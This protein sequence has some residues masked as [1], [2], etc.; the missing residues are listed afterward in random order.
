MA[1]TDDIQG[2]NTQLY[3]VVV[4]DG[5]YYSTN[6]V[7]IDGNY[8]KPILMN[9]PSIKESIDIESRKFKISN[10]SLDFNNFPF[11]GERFSDQL[12]ETSLINKEAIIYFKSSSE[13]KELFRATV[14]RISHDDEKVRV[15]LEDLTEK[16]AHKDLPNPDF[17]LL[18]N[19]NIPKKYHNKYTPLVY[20]NVD[21]CP[22]VFESYNPISG[23][24]LLVSDYKSINGISNTNS[25]YNET[26][27]LLIYSNEQYLHV[28]KDAFS[29]EI[30]DYGFKSTSQY[31]QST[32]K[33]IVNQRI[34]QAEGDNILDTQALDRSPLSENMCQVVFYQQP[35]SY[36]LYNPLDNNYSPPTIAQAA[37]VDLLFEAE[38]ISDIVKIGQEFIHSDSNP[39]N[40]FNH[41]DISLYKLQYSFD[42]S[43]NFVE[44]PNTEQSFRKTFFY[45]I[46]SIYNNFQLLDELSDLGIFLSK[47]ASNQDFELLYEFINTD[48]SLT[49]DSTS[50]M[51]ENSYSSSFI[52]SVYWGSQNWFS[53]NS[54]PVGGSV[55]FPSESQG[56]SCNHQF[57]VEKMY[58][59]AFF[60]HD[61]FFEED[62]YA[63]INGRINTFTDHPNPPQDD[64]IQN[65]IDIIYDILR[66]ELG[67]SAEQINESDYEEARLEHSDWEFGFTVNKKIDSK[68]L[69]EDIAK[70]TKCFPKFRNDGTFGFSVIKDTYDTSDYNSAH[71]IKQS[72]V[73]SYSFKKTKPEQIY[74]QVDVQY[75]MDYAQNSLLSRTDKRDSGASDFYGIES[76][77][78]AYLEFES[79]YIRNEE[80]AENLRDFLAAHYKNDHLIF[81]LKLPLQYIDLEIGEL[82]KFEELFQGLKAY[83]I[84]YT[85]ESEIVE[86]SKFYPLFIITS[87]TK[88]LDSVSIECMQLHQLTTEVIEEEFTGV[89][90]DLNQDGNVNILDV[91]Q[92]MSIVVGNAPATDYS[93]I[94]GD[95][96]EDGGLNVLDVVLMVNSIL[97]D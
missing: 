7:T 15:E 34:F 39:A 30:A 86:G 80:T 3:P 77:D 88:N 41:L 56:M 42:Y 72:D 54:S 38:N 9:I 37:S 81:N 27:N 52:F 23:D 1:F 68:K 24:G 19:E 83:G 32:E 78:D 69:I 47:K 2:Q 79:P 31:E 95:L 92:L 33:F 50:T 91:V 53:A 51:N 21:R 36:K 13:L 64:F 6:N 97:E 29:Q 75:N 59:R 4:I 26:N 82:V 35:S 49:S 28:L 43:P 65:P 14:R 25:F 74:R 5:I 16:E 8:C 60:M 44:N 94:A 66:S 90:G 22:L 48:G 63:N 61:G 18:E 89:L 11:K 85:V 46:E 55:S 12:S 87:I 70:S 58:C 62:F 93:R 57:F 67:L 20:G 40:D 84:D 71:P 17:I 45:R 96:N 10:V 76:P 73:I